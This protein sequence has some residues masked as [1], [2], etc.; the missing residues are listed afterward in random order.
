M[1]GRRVILTNRAFTLDELRRFVAERW[2]QAQ[3]GSF[4]TDP[5]LR[6]YTDLYLLLPATQRYMVILYSRAGGGLFS[7]KNKVVLS[8]MNTPDGM[9]EAI[10]QGIPTRSVLF[11]AAKLGS[12]MSSEQERKGPAEDV[13]QTYTDYM[14]SLLR[15]AGYLA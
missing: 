5:Q 7:K 9:A 4:I 11:G 2:D 14:E 15:Q 13:L 3:Y 6:R 8:V 12:V 10:L 1:I